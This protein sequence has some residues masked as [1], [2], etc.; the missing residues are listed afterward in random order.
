MNFI[1]PEAKLH[2]AVTVGAFSC[3]YDDVEI[4]EGTIIDNNVTIYSGVRIG[5][6][7]HIYAGA[8][9]GGDPQD[10]KFK[11]EKTYAIIGDNTT[12]RE[13]VTIHRGTASKGQTVVGNHCLIMAYCHVAHDCLLHDHIIMSNATQLAGEVVVEDWAIIGG[14]SLVH[15]FTHIGAHVMIQGGSKV[16]KDVPPYIIAAREPISYCGINSVGLNRR[17]FTQEQI[18]AI[19]N[20]YRLVYLSGLNV[21]Q[22]VEQIETSLPP[23]EERNLILEFI[24]GSPRGIVRGY[25]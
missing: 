16:N 5:K 7:C 17:A 11:G 18:T 14:G 22:A 10:L 4:G 8:V 24:K 12:I 13:F 6:N 25:N 20:T 9:I 3:I 15:Q 21:S 19:Q 2:P 23:S 1:H